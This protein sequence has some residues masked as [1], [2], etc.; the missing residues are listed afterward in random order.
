MG[1]WSYGALGP[2]V[3]GILVT[4]PWV[5]DI[6]A[7]LSLGLKRTEMAISFTGIVA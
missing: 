2:V 4:I 7:L 1:S 3:D 6:R 5:P